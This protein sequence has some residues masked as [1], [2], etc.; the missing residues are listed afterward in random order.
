[1]MQNHGMNAAR[2]IR[3]RNATARQ[4]HCLS[5]FILQRDYH[6]LAVRFLHGRVASEPQPAERPFIGL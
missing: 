4:F 2:S 6:W 3:L 1:M 5:F